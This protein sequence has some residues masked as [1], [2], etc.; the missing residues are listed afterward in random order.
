MATFTTLAKINSFCDVGIAGLDEIDLICSEIFQ[1]CCIMTFN[2]TNGSYTTVTTYSTF[3]VCFIGRGGVR[4]IA[5][6]E[7]KVTMW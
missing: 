3:A 4:N 7:S 5:R 1:L 6:D 2:N